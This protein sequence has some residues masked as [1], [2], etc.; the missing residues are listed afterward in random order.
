MIR[1]AALSDEGGGCMVTQG[2]KTRTISL[3]LPTYNEEENLAALYAA[4]TAAAEKMRGYAFQ[5]IFV[6]DCSTDR[7]P[8][9]LE[10]MRSADT[11]VGIIRL[12]RNSGSHAA[13]A[14]GLC[15]CV[16]DAAVIMAADLQDPA[17]DVLP[18]LAAQWEAGS[19]VVWGIREARKGDGVIAVALSRLFYSIANA[20]TSTRQPTTGVGAIL[21]DRAVID[22]VNASP[23]KNSSLSM[24]I[25]WVG[26]PQASVVCPRDPRA[27]GRSKW[28]L[29]K[30]VKLTVDSIIAF[31]YLPMRLMS[32]LGFLCTAAGAVYGLHIVVSRVANRISVEGWASLMIAVLL[33]GGIQMLMLGIL[34]EYLWRAYDEMRPR[35]RY[36]IERNTLAK[37]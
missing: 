17:G 36:V 25:A 6:D 19:K 37:E 23:E 24:L 3:V 15:Y 1:R 8:A 34:G 4:L 12:A 33:I 18:L 7:T 26:F 27:A 10:K 16:G 32:F 31:S 21:L 14:A 22:A 30:K 9:I 13:S 2:K 28:T 11:R 29:G 35:P 5:F 20:V